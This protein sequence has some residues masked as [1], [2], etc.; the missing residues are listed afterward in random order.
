MSLRV[1]DDAKGT[2]I[3]PPNQLPINAVPSVWIQGSDYDVSGLWD[4]PD[5][6]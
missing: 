3:E 6:F 5:L 4:E 1:A 2:L